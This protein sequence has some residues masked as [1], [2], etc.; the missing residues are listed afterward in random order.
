MTEL[1]ITL[2]AVVLFGLSWVL[3]RETRKRAGRPQP[4]HRAHWRHG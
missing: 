4:H 3:N 1:L 2:A